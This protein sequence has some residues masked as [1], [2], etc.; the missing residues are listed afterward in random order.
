MGVD[1]QEVEI[2]IG[3]DVQVTMGT[4]HREPAERA[5]DHR[6]MRMGPAKVRT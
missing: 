5:F 6:G 4:V 3:G 1:A 2:G